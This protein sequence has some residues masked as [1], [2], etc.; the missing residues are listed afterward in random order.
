M[1]TFSLRSFFLL[2]ALVLSGTVHA[3][4]YTKIIIPASSHPAVLSAARLLAQ[5]LSLP[6]SAIQTVPQPTLPTAGEI[7]LMPTPVVLPGGVQSQ[8]QRDG[9]VIYFANGGAVICGARPRSLLYA[10]G[11][12]PLW[13]NYAS[14][15]WVRNPDFSTRTAPF[16]GHKSVA[17]YVATMGVNI[18]IGPSGGGG[19]LVTF[20]DTLP[21]VYAQLSSDDRAAL[22]QRSQDAEHRAAEFAQECHDADVEFYPF[23]YGNNLQLWS[24][25]LYDAAIKAYPSA[26][27]T[28][29]PH[30]WELGTLCPSDPLTWKVIGAYVKEFVQKSHG[31]GLYATFWDHYGLY[32]EDSRCLNDGMNQF[33]NELYA[34]VKQYHDSLAPLG[35]KLIVRTWASGVPHW[36]NDQWVHAPGYGGFT[37]EGSVVWGRVIRELPSDI[38]LQTKVYNSDCQPDAPFSPLLGQE[39]PHTEI[40]EYQITGQTTGRFYF[41]ASTVNHT[42]WTIKKSLELLGH[43]GGVSIFPGGTDQSDYSEFNDILNSINLYAWRQLSWDVNANLDQIWA[44]WATP[45]YGATAAPHVIKALQLSEDVVNHLFS[46]LGMGSGTESGIPHTIQQREVLLKYTNRYYQPDY[47]SFLLPTKDNI[48]RVINEKN[49]CLREIDQMF[50]ELELAKPDLTPAQASELSTRF[51]WLREFAI[52][53]SDLEESLWRYRYLRYASSMLTTDSGQMKYLSQSYDNVRQHAKLMFQF[54]PSQKFSCYSV[55]M[56]DLERSPSLGS[57]VSLMNELYHSSLD[58]VEGQ[59]GPDYLP[60]AWLR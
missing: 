9:Y 57:P 46:T 5:K 8:I 30:S 41:P 28:S 25:V 33:S 21:D 53:N 49:Q 42:D 15:T 45:I 44:D 52:V 6:D 51:G 16:Y 12:L 4:N 2:L 17:D 37:G 11:D 31:D 34:C 54:D 10:A 1:K 38:L 22:D 19:N 20:K 7:V 48:Q 60:Q 36:L 14:G 39:R 40:A 26:R 24:S 55:P 23:L 35:K 56:G 29:V 32:C 27:G 3:A 43:D 59:T 18:I 47:A 50:G 13:Q 58:L